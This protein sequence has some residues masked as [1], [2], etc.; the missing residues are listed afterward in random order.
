LVYYLY[1]FYSPELGRWINRD[2]IEERG[3]VNLYGFV[4]NNGVNITD[5]FGLLREPKPVDLPQKPNQVRPK[6][7]PLP[8]L[9]LVAPLLLTGDTPESSPDYDILD[10]RRY[11]PDLSPSE[12]EKIRK[13]CCR[14]IIGQTQPRV[15][16]A[17]R[18]Y[19]AEPIPYFRLQ[20]TSFVHRDQASAHFVRGAMKR[21]CAI[22]DIGYDSL[23]TESAKRASSYNA[24]A[25]TISD[26]HYKLWFKVLYFYFDS[27]GRHSKTDGHYP[28]HTPDIYR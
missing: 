28:K 22:I 13:A 11:T 17:A 12:R 16:S 10:D 18:K 1:R 8:I 9:I 5:L 24:E 4:N 20:D 19:A 15:N 14:V 6:K 3:G 25:K 7:L 26:A 2:P 23:R 21:K 27:E